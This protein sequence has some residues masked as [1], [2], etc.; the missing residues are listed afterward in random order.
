MADDDDIA[1]ALDAA[2]LYVG[3]PRSAAT[4]WLLKD[5]R[6]FQEELKKRWPNRK[7]WRRIALGL[8]KKVGL[9]DKDGKPLTGRA[10]QDAWYRVRVFLKEQGADWVEFDKPPRGKVRLVKRRKVAPEPVVA[11]KPAPAAAA[12]VSA[13]PAVPTDL[14]GLFEKRS[15]VPK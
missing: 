3:E 2:A 13:E 12:P 5:P 11:G 8:H 10:L 9:A 15:W 7:P 6:A 1:S 4:A 14:Q